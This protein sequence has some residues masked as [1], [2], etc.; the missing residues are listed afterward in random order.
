MWRKYQLIINYF[1]YTKKFIF[2]LYAWERSGDLPKAF[3]V[4]TKTK[5]TESIYFGYILDILLK[6]I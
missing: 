4:N 6:K 5:R 1:S 3:E 2:F